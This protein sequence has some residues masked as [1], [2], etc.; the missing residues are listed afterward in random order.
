MDVYRECTRER[1]LKASGGVV[2]SGEDVNGGA[3]TSG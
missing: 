3:R 2:M 1:F